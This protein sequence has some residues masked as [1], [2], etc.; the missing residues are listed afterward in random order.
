MASISASVMLAGAARAAEGS[1]PRQVIELRT[2]R[3][4]TEQKLEVFADY[5]A[6]ALVPAL[7]RA[8]VQPVGVLRL[9]QADNPGLK[10]EADELKLYVILPHP[11]LASALSLADRLGADAALTARAQTVLGAPLKDPVYER[12]EAQLMLGFSQCPAVEVPSL[13]ATRVLQLRL[14]ESHQD[15]RALR[16]IEMFN[17]GGEIALFRRLGLHPVFFGQSIAGTALPNLTYMLGFESP[18]ALETAWNAFRQDPAWA[19]LKDDPRYADTVSRITNLILRPLP[20][21]QI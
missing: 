1:A 7:N 2:Y 18:A 14:Y 21:S 20:G 19:K 6:T 8:G 13:A 12:F 3:F 5:L 9:R 11:D 15:E 17:Q 16:K 4:A 10:L